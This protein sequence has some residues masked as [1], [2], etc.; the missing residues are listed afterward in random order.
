MVVSDRGWDQTLCSCGS[1]SMICQWSSTDLENCLPSSKY[2]VTTGKTVLE[3]DALGV[4][5]RRVSREW[6]RALEILQVMI[7]QGYFLARRDTV[8]EPS[9]F[10]SVVPSAMRRLYLRAC[11]KTML[12][13]HLSEWLEW[14]CRSAAQSVA[15]LYRVVESLRSAP[16]W[17]FM[18]RKDISW[19]EC[20]N[21][22]LIVGWRLFM[23]FF[24][25]WSCSV[26]PRKIRKTSSMNFFQK[27][28][29]QMKV[30]G[31]VSL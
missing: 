15:F 13:L 12:S 18:S 10:Y 21:V 27:G 22:N 6:R 8:R 17:I 25:D 30:S 20:S 1:F 31:M 11:E 5:C 2:G 7:S 24:M 14:K 4:L 23:K 29:A 26:V 19:V 9:S 28:I 3:F 16:I